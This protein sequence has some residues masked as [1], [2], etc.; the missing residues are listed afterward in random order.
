MLQKTVLL[1]AEGDPE[2]VHYKYE[3]SPA[4]GTVD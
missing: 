1:V 4:P 3:P 2:I